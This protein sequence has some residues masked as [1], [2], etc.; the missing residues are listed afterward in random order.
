[1][2]KLHGTTPQ[3]LKQTIDDGEQVT[4]IDVRQPYEFDRGHIRAPNV[5]TVNVPLNQLQTL[6]PTELL[7]DVPTE[8]VVA[9][10]A[11]GNRSSVATQLLTRA[12]IDTKN[13]Q[14]GMQGWQRVAW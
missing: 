13:L 8:N 7:E 9:V 5:E 11:S 3:E 10:C 4:V 1:M 14:Y 12:G 6:D 2:Q